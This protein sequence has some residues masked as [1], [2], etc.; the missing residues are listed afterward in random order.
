MIR[1]SFE[2]TQCNFTETKAQ[3]PIEQLAAVLAIIRSAKD[4]PFQQDLGRNNAGS[5]GK[6]PKKDIFLRK[7][8]Q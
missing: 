2:W 3:H 7:V 1:C 4:I 6:A 8:M 5:L